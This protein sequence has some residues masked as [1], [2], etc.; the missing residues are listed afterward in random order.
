MTVVFTGS[1]EEMPLLSRIKDQMNLNS[2]DSGSSKFLID[3][4][5][6]TTLLEATWLI[7]NAKRVLTGDTVAMHLAAAMRTPTLAL[8]GP[9]NPVE[10]GPY[11]PGH[12]IFQ[13]YPLPRPNLAFE[14]P[15][16]GLVDFAPEILARF[17]FPDSSSPSKLASTSI[18]PEFKIWQTEWSGDLEMQ[19]LSDTHRKRHPSFYHSQPLRQILDARGMHGEIKGRKVE[20]SQHLLDPLALSDPR[21]TLLGAL[22]Q[23][24]EMP[25]PNS[26]L[27][28]EQS[29]QALAEQTQDSL[30]W[31]SYRIAINGI[32]L[33]N[34]AE[35]LAHRQ[36]RLL[37]ALAEEKETKAASPP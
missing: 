1:K 29:E 13:I 25:N 35:Y 37:L 22:S 30:I 26:L 32:E 2:A 17:I 5:G 16:P 19:V 36:N 15:H 31:E 34:L 33:Q 28:L 14:C 8:F 11:G 18:T 6:H 24:R 21:K 4:V 20:A 12:V 27:V 23:A 3:A 9:S 10:T 7:E